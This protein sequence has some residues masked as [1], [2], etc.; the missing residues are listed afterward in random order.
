M[1][2]NIVLS[3]CIS[4]YNRRE[5]VCE[6]VQKMLQYE[7]D[8]IE[9]IVSDNASEDGTVEAL[10]KIK[11]KR[12][13]LYR[14][15][16]NVELRGNTVLL[17]TYATGKYVMTIN[18]R[19]WVEPID[20]QDFVSLYKDRDCDFVLATK[21]WEKLF[22]KYKDSIEVRTLL[23]YV[24]G[25]PGRYIVKRTIY[26]EL[27]AKVKE[28]QLGAYT[29]D[30]MV[31]MEKLGIALCV[32][33]KRWEQY[34]AILMQPEPEKLARIVQLRGKSDIERLHFTPEGIKYHFI[35]YLDNPYIKK[36]DMEMYIRGLYRNQ[37]YWC[38][39]EYRRH[40]EDPY[41]IARYHYEPESTICWVKITIDFYRDA[42]SILKEKDLYTRRLAL[43][44]GMITL[45]EYF[46]PYIMF[47]RKV[48]FNIISI[49]KRF[50][51]KP[52]LKF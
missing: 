18:D 28:R 41:T 25:H 2:N 7:G 32:Y 24:N 52:W 11:D 34:K 48:V 44:L 23:Y 49:K 20:I 15:E 4:A 9:V 17:L 50:F 51:P 14:N 43:K 33:A 6:N 19:D 31:D 29:K 12:L 37:I 30:W 3:I 47:C 10:K 13:K 35:L 5:L 46:R 8:D 22:Q 21:R 16:I 39:T 1:E 45:K 27:V 42:I 26:D 36:S 38:I 40:I